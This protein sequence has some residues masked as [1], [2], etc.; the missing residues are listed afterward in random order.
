M[1]EENF[2]KIKL[3]SSL[4]NDLSYRKKRRNH[5]KVDFPK[6]NNSF[7]KLSSKTQIY[8]S[9][10]TS[11]DE[12]D[13]EQ[14]IMNQIFRHASPSDICI[15]ALKC[16]PSER[17]EELIKIIG[18]YL[19]LLKNFM[20]IFKGQIENEELKEL[21]YN[22]SSQLKHE[23]IEKNKFIFKYGEKANKFYII[24]KGKV[25]FCVPKLNKQYLN[26]EE[27][28]LL[29]IKLRFFKEID[30]I[31]KNLEHNKFIY[32]L[33]DNFD[34]FVLKSLIK[35]E[36]EEENIYSEEIYACFRKI[37]ENIEKEKKNRRKEKEKEDKEIYENIILSDY[38]ERTKINIS[39][40]PDE[41]KLNKR[42]LLEIY[43]YERTNTFEDGDCFGLVGSNNKNNK[44][45]ATAISFAD[46]ELA[47]LFKDEYK[48]IL[49]KITKKAREKIYKLVISHKIFSTI[50]KN[51]FCNK[52]IHMFRFNRFYLN[53]IIMDDTKQFNQVIMFNS[54]EFIL[55]VN[56][57]IIELNEL[58]I[59][60]K[61]IKG[62]IN[63]IP[64]ETIKK[65]LNEI[66]ENESFQL[67]K[68]YTSNIIDEYITKKQNLIISTVNDKMMLGYPDTVE[69][70]TF[71]PL[72]NCKCTSTSATGYTV[73]RKMI[74]LFEKE[75]YLR[76]TPSKVVLLKIDFYLKRLLQHKKNIMNRIDLLKVT[77]KKIN[78]NNNNIEKNSFE[79]TNDEIQENKNIQN[80]D[81]NN[82]NLNDNSNEISKE[83]NKQELNIDNEDNDINLNFSRNNIN[84]IS[85]KNNNIFE[86]R[87]N[88]ISPQLEQSLIQMNDKNNKSIS[89]INNRINHHSVD[90][91]IYNNKDNDTF[92][93]SISKLK[94]KI[95]K[96][97]YLLRAIQRKSNKF[98]LNENIDKKKIQ[99]KLNKLNYKENYNDLTTIFSK[100]PD[101]KTSIID[102][103]L[104]KNEDNVL[105]PAIN[106]IN[107]QIN[108]EKSLISFLPNANKN[109]IINNTDK[110]QEQSI[111]TNNKTINNSINIYRNN[112][113]YLKKKNKLLLEDIENSNFSL[114][115][116]PINLNNSSKKKHK[117]FMF[118]NFNDNKLNYVKVN[119]SNISLDSGKIKHNKYNLNKNHFNFY[120]EIFNQYIID[121]HNKKQLKNNKTILNESKDESEKRFNSLSNYHKLDNYKI[122]KLQLM[123]IKKERDIKPN[124]FP[125]KEM[126]HS[127]NY[128]K[129]GISLVDPLALD[130]FNEIYRKERLNSY[131]IY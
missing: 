76:T 67:N 79:N 121:E 34:N 36:K 95:N 122:N 128:E 39:N 75:H 57:N 27:Y 47:V 17:S 20:N 52:Y 16:N 123:N 90:N 88:M 10:L 111:Q 51:T 101:K 2:E 70:E 56:K 32:D 25:T 116:N 119:H 126:F 99:I 83:E 86:F 103:Y 68:K 37:K 35:H 50:T 29:L 21:L 49:D 1:T 42:K 44:R 124:D 78:S 110:N 73:E 63:N 129:K 80:L 104:K 81:I 96:K 12:K 106:D 3:N 125:P 46:C 28:I 131:K 41:A 53:N 61:K 93:T 9:G 98:M 77:N 112:N 26:E 13:E 58:I 19:Q 4:K 94:Q 72:F 89:L 18:F 38:L 55:Y 118:Y 24:I 14:R 120:N 22:I 45:S 64:E 7:N 8:Q 97:Q 105:D 5:T 60:M 40:D 33:G 107:K 43:N 109:K 102:K 54:G 69:P 15:N 114:K 85:L 92:F 108:Y 23:H 62:M 100:D 87:R 130:K 30:L 113:L 59:K 84:P 66:K 65:D 91:T 117:E 74:K 31:K 48:K 127:P 11:D 6:I 71:M 115:K 82:L